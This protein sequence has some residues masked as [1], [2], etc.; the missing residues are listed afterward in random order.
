[1][2]TTAI[3]EK[4]NDKVWVLVP[5]YNN[6]ATI[7]DVVRRC[8]KQLKNVLVVDD[9]SDDLDLPALFA[10]SDITVI[11]HPENQGKGA[12]ILTALDYLSKRDAEYMVTVDGDGQHYPEDIPVFF[13]QMGKN[14]YSLIIGCRDFS[15]PNITASSRRGRAIANFWMQ[16]ET[17]LKI[18]DCQSGFR[19]YPV[20]YITQLKFMSRHY[21]FETEA[22]VRAA[23]AGLELHCVPVR[24]WYAEPKLRISHFKPW[25]DTFRISCVHA[26]FTAWRL[27][28]IPHKK[29]IKKDKKEILKLLHPMKFLK[30]LLKENSTPGGLAAAA[31]VGTF[32]A[33]LP[34]PGFH[35][36]AI[37]YFAAKLRLNK[38]MAFNIQHLFMPPLTPIFCM[39][40]GYWLLHGEFLL[41]ANFETLIK[42]LPQRILEWWLGAVITAPLFALIISAMTFVCA[43]IISG[44]IRKYGRQHSA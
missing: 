6:A 28:P 11:R 23:W 34:I 17:G 5:V 15:G 19:A 40:I 26:H 7:E 35:S 24:T 2:K 33:V 37:L 16:V 31:A 3:S 4:L 44:R 42:Q 21:N 32:W 39:E 13:P 18:D 43:R 41:V 38:I 1:M 22:L 29:L 10:D 27:L 20:K 36:A 12:A 14:D 8:R 9:G 25:L 30:Y